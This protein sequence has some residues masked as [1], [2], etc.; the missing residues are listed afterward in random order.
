MKISFVRFSF[1]VL[2]LII[3]HNNVFIYLF[4][5][6]KRKCAIEVVTQ[7]IYLH[8]LGYQTFGD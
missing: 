4:S 5:E 1:V 2:N 6:L 8:I 7:I 3:L